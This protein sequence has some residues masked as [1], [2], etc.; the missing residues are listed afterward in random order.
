[1][2]PTFW[3]SRLGIVM[4]P[5]ACALVLT[6]ALW[7]VVEPTPF[8]LGFAAAIVSSRLGGRQA[9][10]VAVLVGVLGYAL[11]PPPLTHD[12]IWRLLIGFAVIAGSF[13][14]LVARRF[15]IET[16]LR[17]SESRL[18]EAQQV[19][20]IGSWE[21]NVADGSHSWSDEVYRI[22]GVEPGS[23]APNFDTFVQSLHPDDRQMVD[24]IVQQAFVD[25]QP[26]HC[27]CRI[28]RPDGEVR[29][30]QVEARVIGDHRGQV[31]R[32]VGTTQDITNRKRAEEA[33]RRSEHRLQTI[34]DAE[35]ACVKLVSP[36]GTILE[37]NR[38][39]MD[40]LGARSFQ[41]LAGGSVFD[42]V[43][44][45]DRARFL[46][47]HRA[48]CRGTAGRLVFRA[49]T[50]QGEERWIDAHV[51]PFDTAA[52][53]SDVPAATLS[54]AYD[55]TEH[56]RLED[57]LRQS[58][59]MEAVG[60]LAGGIAHDFNN[61]LTAIGGFA[62]L[63]LHTLDDS[64]ERR[65]DL[66][67]VVKATVRAAALT[68]QLLAFSRRQILQPTILDVNEMVA[69]IQKL[70]RRTIPENIELQLEL[71]PAQDAV[72][73]D[74][75]QLEQ[76]LLNLAI[77]AA[78][79]MPQGGQLRIT[80]AAVDVDES[81]TRRYPPMPRGRYVRLAV[82]DTGIG[83]TPETQ[84]RV[85]E[86]FFTTKRPGAGTGLGLA[87]VYGI[88]KQSDGFIWLQSELGRGTTFEVY[89]PAARGTIAR[90]AQAPVIA[91]SGGLQTILLAEDDG[92][93]RRLARDVLSH[94]GYTVMDAR[95]GDE[96]LEIARQ[97]EGPIHLLIADVVMPG[98]SGHD[99]AERLA[100][101]RPSVRVLY[102]SGYTDNVMMRAGFEDGHPLLPKPFLPADLLRKVS[103]VMSTASE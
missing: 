59:K 82:S 53:A 34:I 67:E 6:H 50:L 98:L 97:Y 52:G 7:R 58:Q 90:P 42:L 92:A 63:V 45:D 5:M 83:M 23:V 91:I 26:F 48:A 35:P 66:Q 46:E 89:L 15:E 28:I 22:L 47:N 12:R 30:V 1:M 11:F 99:L 29:N 54:V 56:K 62:E 9:G 75:G 19:A 18:R 31:V 10:L 33:L 25:R 57:E 69:S 84:R 81:L 32:L 76:L 68:R 43:H 103:E 27:D 72:H 8:F 21:W 93:V 2:W 41:E 64:D 44:P 100:A 60:L 40:I 24:T 80:T 3:L 13:G 16:A 39:G 86:P 79:A 49:I 36:D 77:N 38:A 14:W 37:M 101:E 85:F 71:S 88:V 4:A 95:D 102:T 51:V 17:S 78:D 73:A 55:I 65:Q 74:A 61:V 70:L 94:H 20:S 96:A 87:T